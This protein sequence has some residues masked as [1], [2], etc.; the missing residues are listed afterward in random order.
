MCEQVSYIFYP[1]SYY[2]QEVNIFENI[3]NIADFHLQELSAF[4]VASVMIITDL[5]YFPIA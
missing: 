1:N 5:S 3:G 2:R 4:N